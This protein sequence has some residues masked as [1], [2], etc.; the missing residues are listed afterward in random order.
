MFEPL[1]REKHVGFEARLA[2][3][4]PVTITTDP[5]RLRQI[6][7]NLLANAFKFTEAGQVSLTVQ[8]A[9]NGAVRFEVRDTGIGIAPPHQEA[10]FEAFRQ[11]DGTT[12]RRYGGTGLGLSISRELARLLGGDI[13]VASELGTG[14]TFAVTLPRSYAPQM[15]AMPALA[16]NGIPHPVSASVVR[17]GN[18]VAARA[19]NGEAGAPAIDDRARLTPGARA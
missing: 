15:V 17:A 3:G 2:E 18:G 9:E 14:S 11:A 5:Q 7:K 19:S 4:A 6:L 12:H 13:A 16:T 1:A 10:I 8:A